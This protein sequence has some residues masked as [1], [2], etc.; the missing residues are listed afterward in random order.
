MNGAAGYLRF[1][2]GADYREMFLSRKHFNQQ[3][4]PEQEPREI[5]TDHSDEK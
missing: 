1:V 5:D 4:K 3:K 2:D